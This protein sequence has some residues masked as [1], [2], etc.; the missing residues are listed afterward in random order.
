M[1]RLLRERIRR[2]IDEVSRFGDRHG[3][4]WLTYNPLVMRRY[5]RWGTANGPAMA[6]ALVS[7]F[8]EAKRYVDIGAGTGA[9]AAALKRRGLDAVACEYTLAGRLLARLQGVD[10]RPFD[11]RN[12]PPTDLPRD[13]DLAYCLEVAEHLPPDLGERLIQFVASQAPVVVFAAAHPGQGGTG[14]INEQAKPYWIVRFE[15]CG[16]THRAEASR[17]LSQALAERVESAPWL[18]DNVVVF[19]H[20]V[21]QGDG[22]G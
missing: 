19:E 22:I 1:K 15:R 12:E 6:E 8:P 17:Q 10:C 4:D 7:V 14:H 18:A 11:L 13:R 20:A 5:H 2:A 9:F 21:H 16:M 3:V